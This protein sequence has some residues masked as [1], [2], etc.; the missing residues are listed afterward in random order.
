MIIYNLTR[1]HHK[2]SEFGTCC[3]SEPWTPALGSLPLGCGGAVGR[4]LL[5]FQYVKDHVGGLRPARD[6]V[7]VPCFCRK[8]RV[9]ALAAPDLHFGFLQ[10]CKGSQG[11]SDPHP[12]SC[13][14]SPL[15]QAFIQSWL[16]VP[17]KCAEGLR[18]PPPLSDLLP[19]SCL[20][21]TEPT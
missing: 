19:A 2:E 8:Q 3:M 5:H 11:F 16:S 18:G 21:Q 10:H 15:T 6:R 9:G 13:T 12:T 14:H 4:A 7:S 17:G 20:K 1:K